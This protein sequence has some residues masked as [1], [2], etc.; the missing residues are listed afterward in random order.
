MAFASEVTAAPELGAEALRKFEA[1]IHGEVFRP[2]HPGYD[3]ARAVYNAMIDKHP[4][5]IVRCRE[6]SDVQRALEFAQG[7]NLL[8]AVR[9]AVTTSRARHS[10]TTASSSTSRQ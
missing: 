9:G 5:L 4:A 3:P 10:A 1:G 2:G 8:V 7:K 6:V